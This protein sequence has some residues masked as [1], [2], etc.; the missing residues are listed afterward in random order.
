[1][2]IPTFK[3]ELESY[4]RQKIHVTKYHNRKHANQRAKIERE[5]SR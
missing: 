2:A 3:A 1:M 5:K 4:Q